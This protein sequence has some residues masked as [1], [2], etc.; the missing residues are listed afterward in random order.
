MD[1]WDKLRQNTSIF[2]KSTRCTVL[3]VLG[4][5]VGTYSEVSSTNAEFLLEKDIV[6]FL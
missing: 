4:K 3:H 5:V 2:Q 1:K 6:S